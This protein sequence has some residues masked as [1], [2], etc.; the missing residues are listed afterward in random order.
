[1]LCSQ[2]ALSM[3]LVSVPPLLLL[4][5][6]GVVTRTLDVGCVSVRRCREEENST[7]PISFLDFSFAFFFMAFPTERVKA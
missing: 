3:C 4:R 5:E 2:E 7:F 1:M 6:L